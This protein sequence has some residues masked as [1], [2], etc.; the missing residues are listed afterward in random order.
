M[1]DP[2]TSFLELHS[3]DNKKSFAA[4][5]KVDSQWHCRYPCPLEVMRDHGNEFLGFDFKEFLMSCGLN[6]NM[7]TVKNPR[8]NAILER[9]RAAINNHLRFL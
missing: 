4:S 5:R 8:S 2:A 6:P 1:I 7:T 9:A 3:I